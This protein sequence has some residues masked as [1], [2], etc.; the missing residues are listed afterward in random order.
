MK[1]V[2]PESGN[3]PNSPSHWKHLVCVKHHFTCAADAGSVRGSMQRIAT[4][5]VRHGELF[6]GFAPLPEFIEVS[7][8]SAAND[9]LEK[10]YDYCDER[11][12]W[13]Q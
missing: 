4:E 13:L 12:I 11:L 10:L 1:I 6:S 8:L 9:L 2:N 5:L 3:V 7:D